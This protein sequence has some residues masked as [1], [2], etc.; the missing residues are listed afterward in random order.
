MCFFVQ[1]GIKGEGH[2]LLDHIPYTL[3]YTLNNILY[4]I[5][6]FVIGFIISTPYCPRLLSP[7]SEQHINIYWSTGL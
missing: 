1:Q 2:C 7:F 3:L 4:L 5:L 6:H